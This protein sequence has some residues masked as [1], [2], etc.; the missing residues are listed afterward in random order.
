MMKSA[1]ALLGSL[2]ALACAGGPHDLA[3]NE[4]GEIRQAL[5]TPNLTSYPGK[6]CMTDGAFAPSLSAGWVTA[7]SPH[8]R[9]V[10]GGSAF[11][12][13]PTTLVRFNIDEL[14]LSIND[15]PRQ[16]VCAELAAEHACKA[17]YACWRGDGSW[18]IE[19]ASNV[20]C[21]PSQ[22][23]SRSVLLASSASNRLPPLEVSSVPHQIQLWTLNST[24]LYASFSKSDQILHQGVATLTSGSALGFSAFRANRV[25]G[26]FHLQGTRGSGALQA[27]TSIQKVAT[28]GSLASPLSCSYLAPP[29]SDISY[30]W[31]P[32]N[33]I[34]AEG[35]YSILQWVP[36]PAIP[37]SYRFFRG[38][39]QQEF[40]PIGPYSQ[41]F[42]SMAQFFGATYNDRVG[43]TAAD[44]T[45]SELAYFDTSLPPPGPPSLT[46]GQLNVGT[47][48]F[49]YADAPGPA[50]PF[51]PTELAQDIYS[52]ERA[53]LRTFVRDVSRGQADVVGTVHPWILLRHQ[54]GPNVGQPLT[55]ASDCVLNSQGQPSNCQFGGGTDPL[56]A[57]AIAAGVPF[58][59]YERYVFYFNGL[60][61]GQGQVSSDGKGRVWLSAALATE[62]TGRPR[63]SSLIHEMGHALGFGHSYSWVCPGP[64]LWTVVTSFC[65]PDTLPSNGFGQPFDAQRPPGNVYRWHSMH[66]YEMGWLANQTKVH[67]AGSPN[68]SYRIARLGSPSLTSLKQVRVELEPNVFLFVEY[69]TA[70][71]FD[72]PNELN[73]NYI[74]PTGVAIWI[75]QP[76]VEGNFALHS[77]VGSRMRAG[78]F[79]C[80]RFRNVKITVND[81]TI[82]SAGLT[83][84]R[85]PCQ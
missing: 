64:D 36:P 57:Q 31:D 18:A 41:T 20:S 77:V 74:D 22:P 24:D 23:E 17:I 83:I 30:F 84:E 4:Y 49:R 38:P 66:Q 70:D 14:S 29:P 51:T 10:M 53:G 33:P 58:D 55:L 7:Q 63:R 43:Y 15:G 40:M 19:R 71:G 25:R 67:Y 3:E 44:G 42:N 16:E 12:S 39:R 37:S 82:G 72:A 26:R 68:Q 28:R 62:P 9:G 59:S 85:G 75:R 46:D 52:T 80:D 34:Y 32:T 78:D 2:L 65:L 79:Y 54:I 6:V 45:L 73:E 13:A 47:M 61:T 8:A 76:R 35:R 50:E 56:R 11:G 5:V 48:L 60:G 21:D 27:P 1:W 81:V 69:R